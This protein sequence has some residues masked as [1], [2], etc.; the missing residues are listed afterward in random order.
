M[1]YNSIRP[2]CCM[3]VLNILNRKVNGVIGHNCYKDV[4]LVTNIANPPPLAI[5]VSLEG[6][7][8]L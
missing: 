8:G 4:P 6:R 1:I 3:R 7:N 5:S 2:S